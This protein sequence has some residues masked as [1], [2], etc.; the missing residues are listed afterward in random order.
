MAD[1]RQRAAPRVAEQPLRQ[2]AQEG[3]GGKRPALPLAGAGEIV[4]ARRA[5]AETGEAE[6]DEAVHVSLR[7]Q[8]LGREVVLAVD[9]GGT[10]AGPVLADQS[11][12]PASLIGIAGGEAQAVA[13]G[14]EE[15]RRLVEQAAEPAAGRLLP[16]HGLD[17]PARLVAPHSGR[18]RL[19]Q[20]GAE[21]TRS[22]GPPGWQGRR[23]RPA[24]SV[25]CRRS[26]PPPRSRRSGGTPRARRSRGGRRR[27][28]R[29]AGIGTRRGSPPGRRP[30]GGNR[31]PS[32]DR[33]VRDRRRG[34]RETRPWYPPR[35][36]RRRPRIRGRS[37]PA[38]SRPAP[39][40]GRAVG[41]RASRRGSESAE[42]GKITPQPASSSLPGSR[43]SLS[44][45][46]ALPSP[47]ATQ[48]WS[49]RTRAGRPWRRGRDRRAAAGA[50]EAA[51]SCPAG[52]R[53]R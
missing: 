42:R 52:R 34:G 11:P 5:G 39:A 10:R 48:A 6:G 32:P 22:P 8:V 28:G 4:P 17:A 3:S 12:L 18:H 49:S 46:R 38:V 44:P 30:A 40:G 25:R 21:S 37:V 33:P 53:G 9:A 35:G 41:A 7:S 16:E 24:G 47:R 19:R 14:E 1:D 36:S 26:R 31:A 23:S 51:D 45:R 2:A 50:R 27:T 43:P 29:R 15:R 20:M 13:G